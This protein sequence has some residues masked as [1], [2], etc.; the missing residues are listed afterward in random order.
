MTEKEQFYRDAI[1]ELEKSLTKENREYMWKVNGYLM[2]S[3]LFHDNEEEMNEQVYNIYLDVL[4]GQKDGLT[5]KEFLGNQPKE[6]VDGLLRH[7]PPISLKKVLDLAIKMAGVYLAFQFLGE[8]SGTGQIGINFFSILGFIGL[9]FGFPILF[10]QIIK[11]VIYQ[12]EKWKIWFSYLLLPILFVVAIAANIWIVDH[13]TPIL[14]PQ[15]WSLV[16]ALVILVLAG[17]Y[18]RKEMVY[19]IFL[20][21]FLLYFA[22]GLLQI[23]IRYQDISGDFWNKWLPLGVMVTSFLLFWLGTI[24]LLLVKRKKNM[25]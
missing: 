20:P 17:S 15:I 6:M 11:R 2:F 14:L 23:Y 9:A 25:K 1:V 21:I 3:S 5:A 4:E 16:L 22:S 7:L 12:T 10:F 18:W 19:Y 24:V 8:F 13:F